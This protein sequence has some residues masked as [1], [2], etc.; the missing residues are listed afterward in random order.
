MF[1]F[2]YEVART[3]F[4]RQVIYRWANLAGLITNI[5]FATIFSYVIIALFHARAVVTGY[6]VQDTLRYTW[7]TQAMV[8]VV[9]QFSW[10]EL[11]LTI[12]SGDVIS[13]LSKPCDFCWYWFSR[14]IG[15]AC[16][17]LF[18]RAIP[19]YVAG[20]LLFGFGAPYA[21]QSWLIYLL[22]LPLGAILGIAYRFLYNI[23]AFWL[24]EARSIVT[25][26]AV[27]PLLCSG[28]YIPIP[29]LPFW[30]R[31]LMAWLPF[32]GFLNLPVGILLGKISGGE[33]W[34]D[35]AIQ[36]GWLIVFVVIARMVTG[37]AT[38]RVIVQGG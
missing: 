8:M 29:F 24:V 23:A 13:D 25:F 26:A 9:T 14:E 6:D 35:T 18:Y 38:R 22:V 36:V 33:M 10:V 11:M 4:R 1:R 5:F 28:S 19:T 2:Y 31:T 20:M 12:R 30:L 27:I 21:W 32:N 15:R 17:Y 7:L 3:T 34:F 16:Y 37:V